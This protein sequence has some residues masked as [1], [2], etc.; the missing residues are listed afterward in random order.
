MGDTDWVQEVEER[1]L[2]W[3]FPA[4]YLRDS[5]VEGVADQMSQPEVACAFTGTFPDGG[6][7]M[8]FEKFKYRN[9]RAAI[10]FIEAINT[11]ED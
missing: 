3:P 11:T 9:E 5:F 8:D 6:E 1:S 7:A 4:Q 2:T 10:W